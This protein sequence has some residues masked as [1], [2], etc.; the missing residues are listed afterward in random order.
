MAGETVPTS[1]CG[2]T[3]GDTNNVSAHVVAGDRGSLCSNC[4]C[5]LY[6]GEAVGSTT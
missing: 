6:A 2:G 1:A 5:S 3:L 4:I